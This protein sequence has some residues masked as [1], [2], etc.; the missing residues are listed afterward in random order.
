MFKKNVLFEDTIWF[1]YR[2]FGLVEGECH[3][4]SESKPMRYNIRVPRDARIEVILH[5]NGGSV[6]R[7][8][9]LSWIF[10]ELKYPD[11]FFE[12][13]YINL[14]L[15]RKDSQVSTVVILGPN[16]ILLLLY[17]LEALERTHEA[18]F[19]Y[20]GRFTLDD[21]LY[22]PSR[23]LIEINVTP[24]L[25]TPEGYA[26]DLMQT[27][28]QVIDAL[29]RFEDL[30]HLPTYPMHVENLSEKIMELQLDEVLRSKYMKSK[31]LRSL[32]YHHPAT[33]L[34]SFQIAVFALL[35]IQDQ[36]G[37]N[38]EDRDRFRAAMSE[39]LALDRGSEDWT[40]AVKDK[41]APQHLNDVLL[42]PLPNG[43]TKDY[44]A[45]L[46]SHSDFC[47]CVFAHCEVRLTTVI[48][49]V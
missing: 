46:L 20:Y 10:E 48:S 28:I 38:K 6:Q 37:L 42:S 39:P 29:L 17:V 36:R 25:I 27:K 32:I 12:H 40:F 2:E 11:D 22:V 26:Y 35:M 24:Q 49:H 7:L 3:F 41:D 14:E 16:G 18:G 23:K 8:S 1:P 34:C 9:I 31:A 4:E 44:T 5:C 30:D 47:R 43:G 45:G 33:W 15:R 21:L 19:C 13:I